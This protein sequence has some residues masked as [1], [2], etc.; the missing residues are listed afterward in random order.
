MGIFIFIFAGF[1]EEVRDTPN[2][3]C[4][5]LYI[6]LLNWLYIWVPLGKTTTSKKNWIEVREAKISLI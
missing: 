1:Q 5:F 4:I 3:S 2:N 6:I